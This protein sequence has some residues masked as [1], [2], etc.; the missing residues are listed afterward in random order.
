[1]LEVSLGFL[2]SRLTPVLRTPVLKSMA[3]SR[4]EVME[5]A[6]N[7]RVAFWE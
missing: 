5:M 1:M 7:A 3:D 6:P 4:T 2:M